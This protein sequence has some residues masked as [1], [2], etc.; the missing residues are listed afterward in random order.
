VKAAIERAENPEF[1]LSSGRGL[2]MMR[3]FA[4]ELFFNESGNRATLVLYPDKTLHQTS[5]ASRSS[6]DAIRAACQCIK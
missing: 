2:L 5:P 1:L 3:A 6:F 4:D